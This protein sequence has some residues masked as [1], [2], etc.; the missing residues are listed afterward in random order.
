MTSNFNK[1]LDL[2]L[3]TFIQEPDNFLDSLTLVNSLH[4]FTVLASDQPYA[5]AL[6]GQKVTPV[7]TDKSDLETFR[8][9]QASARQ[10]NWVERPSLEV[11]E[12]VINY[13][14][15]GMV[16][17]VKRSGDFG[18]TTV[19]KTSELVAFVTTY[20]NV[21][22]TLFDEDNQ[23][24][25]LMERYYLVPVFI[26]P[27]DH[28]GFERTFPTMSQAEHQSYIPLFSNLASFAKWYSNPEF[29]IPF[30]EAQ[31]AVLTW[32]I[33][34]VRFPQSGTEGTVGLALDPFDEEHQLLKWEALD[35]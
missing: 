12:E 16:Y 29:G 14:L 8:K 19:F 35:N 21:I 6:E 15:D 20:T 32:K 25:G 23:K 4:S 18:N 30:R 28:D 2:A 34:D 17:N 9:Q 33:D 5:I 27:N 26:H 13:Q 3:R 1:E 11:L 10:Q 31:G 7:F 24:A 22:N